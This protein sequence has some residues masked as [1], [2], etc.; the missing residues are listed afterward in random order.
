MNLITGTALLTLM[1]CAASVAQE[2]MQAA[3]DRLNR[4]YCRAYNAGELDKVL[5]FFADDAIT[6]SPD[7]APVRGREALR[8]YYEEGFRREKNRNLVLTSIRAEIS[9]GTLYDAGQWNQHLP[10][11]E[12]RM[13]LFTGYYLSVYRKSGG[14]WKVVAN[15]FNLLQPPPGQSLPLQKPKQ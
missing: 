10:T 5:D 11:A 13:Q 9:D 12:G 6:L 1:M 14:K 15:T 7:Q 2:D 3:I 8:R 4:E